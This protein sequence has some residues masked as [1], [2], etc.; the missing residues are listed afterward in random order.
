VVELNKWQYVSV[1]MDATGL[2]RI[3]KDGAQVKSGQLAVMP[4]NVD[5]SMNYIGRSNWGQDSLYTGQMRDFSAWNVALNPTQMNAIKNA[6]P[7]ANAAGLVR[8]MPLMDTVT[9]TV[10][11]STSVSYDT[12]VN[13]SAR[14]F[15]GLT[16]SMYVQSAGL[17]DFS[18]GFSAG[19]WAYPTSN[20][21]YGRFFDFGNGGLQ[22]QQ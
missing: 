15:D 21:Q 20:A 11:A 19:V 1:S 2:V 4:A 17:S 5:R 12:G 3:Y 6:A 10:P 9:A 8:Y 13:V 16:D 18:G 7:A 14:H 22:W